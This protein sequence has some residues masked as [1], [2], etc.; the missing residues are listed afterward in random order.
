MKGRGFEFHLEAPRRPTSSDTSEW[1]KELVMAAYWWVKT[2]SVLSECNLKWSKAEAD[3][4]TIP[5][6]ET[7]KKVK[8]FDKLVLYQPESA[9]KKAK[10]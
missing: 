5:T 1:K 8:A 9:A 6:I 3:G 10:A 2:S 4:I 7:S